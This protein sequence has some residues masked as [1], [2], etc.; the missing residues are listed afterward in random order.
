MGL[1][2]RFKQRFVAYDFWIV[3]HQHDFGMSGRA[4][5]DFLIR[6]VGCVTAGI[7]DCGDPNAVAELPEKPF[8]A[9]KASKA[10]DGSFNAGRIRRMQR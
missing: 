6:R 8:R 2:K 4:A 7:A 9:P 10:E 3:G 1:P 5:A